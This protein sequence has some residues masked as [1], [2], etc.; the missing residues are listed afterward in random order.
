MVVVPETEDAWLEHVADM[1]LRQI[2][3]LVAGREEGDLPTDPASPV[4]R[5]RLLSLDL[6]PETYAAL[7]EARIVL[8]EEHGGAMTDDELV[9]ALVRAALGGERE[10]APHQISVVVCEQCG[11]GWQDG[12][13]Q[14][15]AI[16]GDAVERAC[17]DSE[18]IGYL[19]ADKPER[20]YQA[21]PPATARLVRT[22]D[23]GRCRVPG[24][25]S[26]RSLEIHHIV[27]REHGGGHDLPN[28]MLIC[29]SCHAAH[30]SGRLTISGT[31]D[32]LVVDRSTI[33]ARSHVGPIAI[34]SQDWMKWLA[35][36]STR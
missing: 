2:E 36:S 26:A 4:I 5:N 24:C 33:R 32:A 17:C 1:N 19:D 15:I 18:H 7:R 20:A 34:Q 16:S 27:H 9:S 29:S 10:R 21:V 14:R 22:R 3:D 6:K 11:Q 12:A 35:P 13:G 31:A 23:R 28:L 8:E 25:R 30:H